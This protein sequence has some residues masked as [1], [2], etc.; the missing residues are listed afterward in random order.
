M[1][2]L[3]VWRVA[4]TIPMLWAVATALFLLLSAAPG[5]PV[6]ALSGEFADA[7]TVA[8]LEARL[9]LDR[10][11]Y[12]RYWRFMTLL[13]EGD[14][15]LS[16]TYKRPVAEVILAHLPATLVLVLPSIFFAAAIGGP[17]GILTARHGRAGVTLLG[18]SLIAFAVPVFWLGHLLRLG[19]ASEL[20]WLPVQGMTDPRA[21]YQGWA[22]VAD[23]VRHAALPWMTLTLHQLAFTVLITRSAVRHETRRPYFLTA[24]A[25]GLTRW[26]AEA[27][28]ALPNGAAPL[29][30]LFGNRLG[31][32][33]TGAVL[34]ETVFAWP[35]LGQL[36]GD[37]IQNRDY[38]LVIGIVLTG[39]LFTM[40]GNLVADLALLALD[41]RT[42]TWKART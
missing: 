21:D 15:G 32:L 24:L 17:M 23:V 33:I 27:R 16:Y 7:D 10:P 29:L 12:E 9:G 42:R 36:V 35:G 25:K 4:Q 1:V 30:A 34:V 39:A 37:A 26:S 28:H 40:A 38:P 2:K 31:W 13:G 22:H 14:L 6:A 5:G 19:I 41:P 3:A 11:L 18:F 8:A 20:G